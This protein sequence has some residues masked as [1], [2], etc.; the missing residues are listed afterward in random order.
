MNLVLMDLDE[1]LISE[2]C[3]LTVPD[4]EITAAIQG[5]IQQDWLIG[6]NS[7]TPLVP[8]KH[9]W[10]DR[11]N[12]NGPI[13]AE[14]GAVVRLPDGQEIVLSSTGPVFAEAKKQV[15]ASLSSD[16]DIT[17]LI[18][19]ATEF[20]YTTKEFHSCAPVLVALNNFRQCSLSFFVRRIEEESRL[21]QDWEFLHS[22]VDRVKYCLPQS[23]T[24]KWHFGET[25][26]NFII[27]DGDCDKTKA[28]KAILAR[29]H[30]NRVV[31]LGNEEMDFIKDLRVET[32]A[33]ANASDGLKERASY[34][35]QESYTKGV[36]EILNHLQGGN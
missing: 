32:M 15:I 5:L 11:L 19:D 25:Y 2:S 20:V 13:I 18:G 31:M 27:N 24:F 21:L 28:T 16:S 4:K 1:T 29:K 33:V 34:V 3:Q 9:W 23:Q 36:I 17:V 7:D 8:L 35:A 22:V 12:M 6:L 26:C 10:F 30:F 14:L